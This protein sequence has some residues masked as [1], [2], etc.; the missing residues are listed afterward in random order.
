MRPSFP[1]FELWATATIPGALTLTDFAEIPPNA[2]CATFM[3]QMADITDG[4]QFRVHWRTEN[5]VDTVETAT[6]TGG[7]D[8]IVNP[9]DVPLKSVEHLSPV[10]PA[11][12]NNFDFTI[13]IPA[14]KV[15]VALE[16]VSADVAPG[17]VRITV[18][19]T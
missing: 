17:T 9:M 15:E 2:S 12:Y 7:I 10:A 18:S 5:G 11:G 14:N 16:I 19:F 3:F 13:A 1:I 4:I 6:N 8:N